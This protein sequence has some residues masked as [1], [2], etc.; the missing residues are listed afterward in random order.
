MSPELQRKLIWSLMLALLVYVAIALFGDVRTLAGELQG[1]PWSWLPLVIGL[2]LINY[3]GRL[4]KWRW[5]LQLLDIPISS[6]DSTRIFGVGMLMVMTPGK[7]GEFLKSYMVKNVTGTAMSLT[8]PVVLAERITD[9]IAMLLL[10]GV[11]LFVFP[12]PI[13][14]LVAILVFLGFAIFIVVMQFRP[15]AL[16]CLQLGEKLP[17]FHKF[18]ENLHQF[19]ESSYTIFRPRNLLIA[20]GIG[21]ISWAAEGLAYYIVLVGFGLGSGL[22]TLLISI[23]I[24]SISVVIG[25]VI[26]LPGGL[27]GV[28]G[29]LFTLSNQILGLDIATATA[30]ALLIRFCTLWLGVLI[31][32]LSFML[33]S[34]LLAGSDHVQPANAPMPGD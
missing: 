32:I 3:V 4:Y 9:G 2:T 13:A 18:A 5:Y 20:L 10:A 30:A 27:G 22:D 25:A 21:I 8:A 26:A 12:N 11:G 28:E 15:L 6:L 29:S 7:A 33:W 17:L 24:F 1:W 31:G 23:F 14:R 19:Y 16:W 34:H